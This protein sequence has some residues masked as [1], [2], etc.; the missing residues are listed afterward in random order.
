MQKNKI[1]IEYLYALQNVN[2]FN[3]NY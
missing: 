1:I 3:Q 2:L